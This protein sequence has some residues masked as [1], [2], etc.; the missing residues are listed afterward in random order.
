[1][2]AGLVVGP[3]PETIVRRLLIWSLVEQG[4]QQRTIARRIG[5]SD[6]AVSRHVSAHLE[7]MADQRRDLFA[8]EY[9]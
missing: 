4:L 7:Q 1:V 8:D 3:R 9:D 5:I 2:S 6:S